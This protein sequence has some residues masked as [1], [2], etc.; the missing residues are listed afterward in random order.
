MKR[1]VWLTEL[2]ILAGVLYYV[3][4]EPWEWLF[5]LAVAVVSLSWSVIMQAALRRA[6]RDR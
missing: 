1:L 2:V 5:W 3:V 4:T 6:S